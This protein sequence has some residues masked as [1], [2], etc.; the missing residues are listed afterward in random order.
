MS[1]PADSS[2]LISLPPHDLA[3][4]RARDD[5]AVK[6]GFLAQ[7]DSEA[8]TI[9]RSGFRMNEGHLDAAGVDYVL[10][11]LERKGTKDSFTLYISAT[12]NAKLP[13]PSEPHT[14]PV[15]II[16]SFADGPYTEAPVW[17]QWPKSLQLLCLRASFLF[18]FARVAM[19]PENLAQPGLSRAMIDWASASAIGTWVQ[20]ERLAPLTLAKPRSSPRNQRRHRV[21]VRCQGDLVED[22]VDSSPTSAR[23]TT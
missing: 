10:C 22:D 20:H 8:R 4:W 13:L 15:A 11:T 6:I 7:G 14:S 16:D 17:R 5:V 9:R 1:S 3:R 21:R 19:W 2:N 18:D 12:V 23:S